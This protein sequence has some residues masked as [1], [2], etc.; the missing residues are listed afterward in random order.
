MGAGWAELRRFLTT[1]ETAAVAATPYGFGIA[2]EH[3]AALDLL[4]EFEEALFVESLGHGDVAH[5]VGDFREAF[6]LGGLGEGGVH[7][8]VL[9]VLATGGGLEVLD[10][11]ADDAG[12]E[13]GSHFNGA[14]LQELEEALGVLLLLQGGFEEDVG[15]E[16]EAFLLSFAGEGIV[17]VAGLRLAAEGGE[18]VFLGLGSL[19]R[20]H[21]DG[22]LQKI[23]RAAG[24]MRLRSCV[25]RKCLRTMTR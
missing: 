6:L 4:A 17:A 11:G 21:V 8:G 9:F 19:E 10:R 25:G 2:F 3:G 12:R 24:P 22:S 13:G 16:H 1:H 7:V 23:V 20:F 18:D 5:D 15:H 14:A